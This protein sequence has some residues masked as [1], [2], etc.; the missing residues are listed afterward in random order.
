MFYLTNDSGRFIAVRGDVNTFLVTVWEGSVMRGVSG[1]KELLCGTAEE[2]W[3]HVC[4]Q[5]ADARSNGYSS[6]PIEH[7]PVELDAAQSIVAEFDLLS[8]GIY[9]RVKSCTAE[10]FN[11]G[12]AHL[13]NVVR[14]LI[15]AGHPLGFV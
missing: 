1:K 6:Q 8:R 10:Q 14:V 2:A 15:D 12:L 7:S 3:E 11:E 9:V 5:V 13:E 4:A